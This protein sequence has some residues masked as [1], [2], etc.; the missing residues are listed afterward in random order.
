[1][2]SQFGNPKVGFPVQIALGLGGGWVANWACGAVD[3]HLQIRT[4]AVS[5]AVK[6]AVLVAVVAA[7][8]HV[9]PAAEAGWQV[10]VPGFFFVSV[11]FGLQANFFATAAAVVK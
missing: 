11:F 7:L 2:T 6:S 1:M 4:P 10:D 5:L 9:A 8:A 3:R